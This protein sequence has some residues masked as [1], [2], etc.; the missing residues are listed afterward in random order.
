MGSRTLS[1]VVAIIADLNQSF[2]GYIHIFL[3][4]MNMCERDFGGG[5]AV[6]NVASN[7]LW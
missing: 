2:V 1:T 6:V 3:E 5:R 4:L 7:T